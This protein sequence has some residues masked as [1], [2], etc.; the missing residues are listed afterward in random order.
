MTASPET[1]LLAELGFAAGDLEVLAQ[2]PVPRGSVAHGFA[3]ELP[4]ARDLSENFVDAALDEAARAAARWPFLLTR[5]ALEP[6]VARLE[7]AP[8]PKKL[9][10]S[11][12][13]GDGAV[14]LDGRDG[15][16]GACVIEASGETFVVVVGR[17]GLTVSRVA[18][19]PGWVPLPDRF[20]EAPPTTDELLAGRACEAWLRER[21]GALAG[22]P[23]VVEQAAAVG[24]VVRLW[25]PV[26]SDRAAI[27]A[28]EAPHPSERAGVWV[29]AL[30]ESRRSLAH[31]IIHRA[32]TL[33]SELGA[34]PAR[35]DDLGE[36]E[37]LALLYERD[38]LESARVVLSLVGEGLPVAQALA[39][40]DEIAETAW[41]VIAPTD[42][43]RDD[44]LL[45]AVF[46]SEPDAFWGNV[47]EP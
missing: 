37:I 26:A 4:P 31:L 1:S 29:S 22:A 9:V 15:R 24:L 13:W 25:E 18:G 20:E 27:L 5:H 28:G 17:E 45:R 10:G 21:A 41:D 35:E 7:D 36:D 16:T 46:R 39:L 6:G 44:P 38:V 3:G 12:E 43:M 23:T 14:L 30:G 34:L 42:R 11:A 32:A 19:A 2:L 33:G 8:E 40:T 47:A